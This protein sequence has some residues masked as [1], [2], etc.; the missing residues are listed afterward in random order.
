[1]ILAG[2]LDS[3]SPFSLPICCICSMVKLCL[4][5]LRFC[6]LWLANSGFHSPLPVFAFSIESVLWES[7]L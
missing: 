7:I 2:H 6:S 3:F 4:S 5:A 1:V